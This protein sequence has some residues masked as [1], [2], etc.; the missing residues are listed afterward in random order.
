MV[1]MTVKLNLVTLNL[2]SL[3]SV[4]FVVKEIEGNLVEKQVEGQEANQRRISS[5]FLHNP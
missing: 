3:V 1:S 5:I 4:V 2:I